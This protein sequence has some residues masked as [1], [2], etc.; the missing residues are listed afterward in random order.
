MFPRPKPT[1][2]L[3]IACVAAFCLST[4]LAQ[5]PDLGGGGFDT[6]P[7][8]KKPKKTESDKPQPR[9]L[10]DKTEWNFGEVWQ[11][12]DVQ[13]TI[14]IKN[15]GN[16]PLEIT[17]KSSCGCTVPT[18]PKNPLLPGESDDMTITY[19]TTKR[20]GPA[21]QRITLLTNDPTQ[22]RVTIFVRGDVKTLYESDPADGI[23]F[24]RMHEGSNI[25]KDTTIRISY[26]KKVNIRMKEGGDF[27]PFKVEFQEVEPGRVYKLSATTQPPLDRGVTRKNVILLTDLDTIPEIVVPIHCYV[28]PPVVLQP[29]FLRATRT[30][31]RE[32]QKT[33]RM[34]YRAD[35]PIR[36]V[37]V[38]PSHDVI[39]VTI[40]EPVPQD[41]ARPTLGR[42]EIR[43]TIPPG[44]DLPE[45]GPIGVDIIT[46]SDNP[47]YKTLHVPIEIIGLDS[48]KRTNPLKRMS[49][50]GRD[51]DQDDPDTE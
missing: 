25:T 12:T 44:K 45:T 41:P 42:Q 47:D 13:G 14:K 18:K 9:I 50:A 36:I 24:G 19:N 20:R 46:D 11:G 28:Q 34:R 10:V 22:P 43:V 29:R 15:V 21:N 4:G 49:A 51:D 7:P 39:K 23:Y 35:K 32:I 17:T 2:C 30:A 38:K 3:T 6:K 40:L 31:P 27:G 48:S 26:D 1:R 8:Q 37:D 16:A 33:V 5:S